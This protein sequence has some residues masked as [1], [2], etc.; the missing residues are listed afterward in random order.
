MEDDKQ[1]SGTIDKEKKS[2]DHAMLSSSPG[3]V[4]DYYGPPMSPRQS[5]GCLLLMAGFG[6]TLTVFVISVYLIA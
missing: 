1:S 2:S 4:S 3:R 6:L 5:S